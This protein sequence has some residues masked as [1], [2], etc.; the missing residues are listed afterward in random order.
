MNAYKNEIISTFSIAIVTLLAVILPTKLTILV[1][2]VSVICVSFI[3]IA[4]NYDINYKYWFSF[5]G[6]LFALIFVAISFI[7]G[8]SLLANGM[9]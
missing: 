9:G 2:I 4:Q 8:L 5:A 6:Q 1:F 3:S 7:A